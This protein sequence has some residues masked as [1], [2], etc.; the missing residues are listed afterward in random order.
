VIALTLLGGQNND[1]LP[2]GILNL[3][4]Q[5]QTNYAQLDAGVIL[6]IL[7]MILLFFVARKYLTQGVASG[8]LKS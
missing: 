6:C 4:G 8:A 3:Q 5:F 7:P 2:L 1:T